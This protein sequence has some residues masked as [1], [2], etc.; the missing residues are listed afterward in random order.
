MLN[1]IKIKNYHGLTLG[2]FCAILP[3]KAP[4][5]LSSGDYFLLYI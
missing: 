1:P 5:F 3:K 2:A 4:F